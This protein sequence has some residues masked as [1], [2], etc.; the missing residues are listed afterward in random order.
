MNRTVFP[1]IS[2]SS[3][4]RPIHVQGRKDSRETLRKHE[5][6]TIFGISTMLYLCVSVVINL[7]LVIGNG[8]ALSRTANAYYVFYSRDPHLA[9]IGFVWPPLPSFLQLPLLPILRIFNISLM[10]GPIVTSFFGAGVLVLLN[11]ILARFDLPEKLRWLLVGLTMIHP[12][13]LYLSAS[14]MS[15]P[16]MLFFFL[17]VVWGFM[18]L[19]DGAR[20]WV[21]CGIGLA[22]AF[23]VRYE[24]LAMMAGVAVGIIIIQWDSKGDWRSEMEGRL[25]AVLVPPAYS[26]IMWMFFNWIVMGSPFY[27]QK[28]EYSLAAAMDIAQNVGVSHPLYL[29]WGNIFYTLSYAVLRLFQ[30]NVEFLI[31]MAVVL[32]LI[33]LRKDK[34]MFALLL[35]MASIPAFTSYQVFTGSLPTWLR[36]W[37]SAIAFGAVIIGMVYSLADTRWRKWLVGGL[38]AAF[39]ASLPI[40]L[41]TMRINDTGRDVQRFSA[42]LVAPQEE[43]PLRK[44]DGYYIY[45]HDAPIIARELDKVSADGLVMV[46]A[47]KSYSIIM[48]VQHPER[49]MITNDLDFQEA[50]EHP[51]GK[52]GYILIPEIVN[53]FTKRYPGMFEGKLNW[54]ELVYDFQTT[55]DHW[56]LYRVLPD[57]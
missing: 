27:F 13:F 34:K 18:Q 10:A 53:I 7:V 33:L 56:K 45:R 28:S 1:R 4:F 52:V 21:A 49:L 11:F 44:D 51:Q 17:V 25:L 46:D 42:Y 31:G 8:D 2:S 32:F 50:F 48:M 5:T 19:P 23:M 30:Q 26:V 20:S 35:V 16:L 40:S 38:V 55:M 24:A 41:F 29:A 15:E 6:L 12:N 22:L 54:V 3:K 47:S 36:Y 57:R 14:G 9:A 39:I 43:P 37:Y